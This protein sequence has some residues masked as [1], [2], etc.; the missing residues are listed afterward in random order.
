MIN[1]V[2]PHPLTP[3]T[4][5]SSHFLQIK[6]N[7]GLFVV[8]VSLTPE[9]C[10]ILLTDMQTQMMSPIVGGVINLTARVVTTKVEDD[11]N[12]QTIIDYFD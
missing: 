11:P 7:T 9:N 4:G 2:H 12:R 3:L 8:Y 1:D 10:P 5:I 6:D